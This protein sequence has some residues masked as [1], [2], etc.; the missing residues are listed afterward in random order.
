MGFWIAF[1]IVAGSIVGT[2]I[3]LAIIRLCEYLGWLD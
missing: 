2:V 1:G 3:G